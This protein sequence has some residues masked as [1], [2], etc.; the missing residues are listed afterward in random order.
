NVDIT[1]NPSQM[2][3]ERRRK[4]WHWFLLLGIE[5]RALFPTLPDTSVVKKVV[6]GGDCLTNERAYSAQTAM[7]NHSTD[8][9][10][11]AGVIHRPEGLHRMKMN[12]CLVFLELLLKFYLWF[13]L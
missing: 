6:F 3:K 1:R 9:E 11:L 8:S 7:L 10:R 4:S 13:S 2:S 5:K 12:L